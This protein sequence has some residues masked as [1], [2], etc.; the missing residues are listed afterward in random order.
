MGKI[1][2]KIKSSK[3]VNSGVIKKVK[4]KIYYKVISPREEKKTDKYRKEIME[5]VWK[6]CDGTHWQLLCGSFLRFYR[7]N[8]MKGQDLDYSIDK[9]DFDK[10]KNRFFEEGFKLKQYFVNKEE[11]ITEYKFLYH[12]VEIDFFIN[13]KDKKCDYIRLTAE[14]KDAK[15]IEKKIDGNKQIVSGEDYCTFERKLTCFKK[16]KVYEYEGVKFYGPEDA[17]SMMIEIYG[18]GWEKYDPNYDPRT[19]PSNNVPK[20]IKG[21]KTIVFIKPVD[22]FDELKK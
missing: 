3:V 5:K 14:I 8:T 11:E 10:I 18:E 1:I 4:D 17:V 15:K 7:D 6:I 9:E 16:S 13:K 21:A 19:C 12:D 22:S 20:M 2:T